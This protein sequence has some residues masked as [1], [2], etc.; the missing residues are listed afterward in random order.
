M[1]TTINFLRGSDNSTTVAPVAFQCGVP[2]ADYTCIRCAGMQ[3]GL[4][5]FVGGNVNEREKG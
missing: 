2:P 5:L 1:L 3:I 4:F